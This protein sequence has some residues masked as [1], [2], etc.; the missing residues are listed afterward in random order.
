MR[1]LI[2]DT[3]A[4]TAPITAVSR[5]FT[6]SSTYIIEQPSAHV[7]VRAHGHGIAVGGTMVRRQSVLLRSSLQF[8]DGE[9]TP[10]P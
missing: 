1:C 3:A 8:N 2:S 4:Y 5:F 6:V 7:D 10:T 9:L